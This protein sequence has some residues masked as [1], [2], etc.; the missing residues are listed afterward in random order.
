M[1]AS[2]KTFIKVAMSVVIPRNIMKNILGGFG[3]K[4]FICFPLLLHP[5]FFETDPFPLSRKEVYA[6]IKSFTSKH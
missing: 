5:P 1:N 4:V 2:N 6:D 3:F